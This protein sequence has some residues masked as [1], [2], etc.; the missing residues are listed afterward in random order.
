[1]IQRRPLE[2]SITWMSQ[3]PVSSDWKQK[4][5]P[6]GETLPSSSSAELSSRTSTSGSPTSDSRAMSELPGDIRE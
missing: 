1:M 2:I 4:K 3:R 6:S 5:L